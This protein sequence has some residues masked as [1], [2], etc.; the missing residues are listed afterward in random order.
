MTETVFVVV[1]LLIWSV[2]SGQSTN[3]QSF[4]GFGAR[5]SSVSSCIF[6]TLDVSCLALHRKWTRVNTARSVMYPDYLSVF[7][8]KWKMKKKFTTAMTFRAIPMKF[9]AYGIFWGTNSVAISEIFHLRFLWSRVNKQHESKLFPANLVLYRI[10]Q[11]L[12]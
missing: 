12:S 1:F 5:K 4:T 8:V 7:A 3:S 2:L 10:S 6:W 11:E 9:S